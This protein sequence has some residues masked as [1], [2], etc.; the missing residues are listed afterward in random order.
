MD[1][2]VGIATGCN[3]HGDLYIN[4]QPRDANTHIDINILHLVNYC[5]IQ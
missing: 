1:V 3:A 5:Y 2:A 4:C